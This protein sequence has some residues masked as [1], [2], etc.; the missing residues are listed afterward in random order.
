MGALTGYTRNEKRYLRRFAC[1][2]CDQSLA[3]DDCSAIWERCTDEQREQ[4]R[5]DCLKNYKPRL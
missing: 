2:W 1:A 5:R 4:R 3:R